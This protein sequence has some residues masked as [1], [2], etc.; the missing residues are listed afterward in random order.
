MCETFIPSMEMLYDIFT[1]KLKYFKTTRHSPCSNKF[2]RLPS[3]H[4]VRTL[5]TIKS[6][7]G[8]KMT[9]MFSLNP[10]FQHKTCILRLLNLAYYVTE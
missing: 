8:N 10:L 1:F 9:S 6:V 7:N 5:T 3:A 2:D 4:P